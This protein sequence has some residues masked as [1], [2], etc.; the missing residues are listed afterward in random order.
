[1]VMSVVAD[2]EPRWTFLRWGLVPDWAKDISIGQKLI[3]A[4]SET[5]MEKPSYRSAFKRRRCLIPALGYYEWLRAGTK[6]QP[7]FFTYLDDRLL[8]G[9]SLGALA[10]A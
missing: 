10:I 3:N 5:V 9:R 8:D 6:K 2:P 4:R 7:Y 1:M